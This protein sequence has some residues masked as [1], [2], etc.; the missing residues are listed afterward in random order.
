MISRTAPA[1]T[2]TQVRTI[3]RDALNSSSHDA[4]TAIINMNLPLIRKSSS[5]KHQICTPK[6]RWEKINLDSYNELTGIALTALASH[7]T[8]DT[9]TNLLIERVNTILLQCSKELSPA[10]PPKVK[11]KPK[12]YKW[13][14]ELKEVVQGSK[15]SHSTWKLNGRP[16][17]P[18]NPLLKDVNEPSKPS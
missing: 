11:R 14:A 18:E 1:E 7:L 16:K 4:V 3:S 15:K 13:S 8:E 6:T 9:P 2:I 12:K 10:E 17:D 5:N